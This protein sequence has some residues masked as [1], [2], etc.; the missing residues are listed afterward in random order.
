MKEV[1]NHGLYTNEDGD[2]DT[3]CSR[4]SS[5][6][7]DS[8]LDNGNRYSRS[9][10]SSVTENEFDIL[11]ITNKYVYK[12]SGNSNN[13]EDEYFSSSGSSDSEYDY[14]SDSNDYMNMEFTRTKIRKNVGPSPPDLLSDAGKF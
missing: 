7:T 9:S 10:E 4:E 3:S 11:N 14:E 8:I 2:S 6:S 5:S 12:S 13:G 1:I